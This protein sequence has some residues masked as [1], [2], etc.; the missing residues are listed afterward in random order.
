MTPL[1]IEEALSLGLE[2][3]LALVNAVRGAMTKEAA[4]KHVKSIIE[5]KMV[6]DADVDA[7]ARGTKPT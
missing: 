6:I 3:T 2:L 4:L 1:Q 5:A 7:A